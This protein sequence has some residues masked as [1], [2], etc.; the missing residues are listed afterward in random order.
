MVADFLHLAFDPVADARTR[1]L[2][3][4]SLPGRASLSERRYY[5]H[6]QN[7]FWRLL[8]P[9]IGADLMAL[10]YTDRLDALLDAGVGLWD[11]YASARRIGSLDRAIRDP[12]IRDLRTLAASLPALRAIA[13][14]GKAAFKAGA[15][16]L[17]EVSG[18]DLIAL[19]S[20][21][22]AHTIGI[23]AKQA[24]WNALGRYLDR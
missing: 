7:Q 21:S 12:E 5:A 20:S 23:V 3:L 15:T 16:A 9:L 1:L 8:G 18:I 13:F 14:N 10:A 22:A 11:V 6:P 2:I 24:E 4:G 19:P 17:P